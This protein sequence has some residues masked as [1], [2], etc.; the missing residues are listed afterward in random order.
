M[1]Y[2]I[3]GINHKTAPIEIREKLAL[4]AERVRAV[5]ARLLNCPGV[6]ESAV[7]S[8]CNRVEIYG[9]VTDASHARGA[10][11]NFFV[12]ELA[13]SEIDSSLYAL[14]DR[15]AVS[16]LFSVTASLDS[17]VVGEN[18]I[19]RQVKDAYQLAAEASA[20]GPY[21]NRL[22][23]RALF[24][25]KRIRSETAIGKGNVSVGSA[26][27]A[28][29]KKIFGSLSGKNVVLFGA[30]E[31]GELVLRYLS[32]STD[33]AEPAIVNRSADKAQALA[34]EGLGRAHA[35]TE[36]GD[37]LVH[38][39]ILITSVTDASEHLDKKAFEIL[40][41]RRRHRPL[42]IID[43]GLPRNV[44]DSVGR[45]ANVYLYNIDD[46]K[47]VA[48]DSRLART[49]EI[50]TAKNIIAEETRLFYD[51]YLGQSAIPMIAGLNR[52]FEDIRRREMERTLSRLT[53]LSGSDKTALDDMTKAIVARILH[54]PILHLK[55][56]PD[57]DSPVL[58]ALRK[59]FR[60][61]DEGDNE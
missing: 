60:L 22:F 51:S 59:I 15:E 27:V 14:T 43:L 58:G 6:R 33:V 41:Q 9:A 5:L 8:T 29:A 31:V 23:N 32:E 18:Q 56:K 17:L 2:V 24:V 52:K 40:M 55:N 46:L 37:L 50:L 53:H 11:A 45:L 20:T 25:A 61:D 30:G 4:T 35:L 36:L 28:L 16:H 44:D 12:T 10:L 42:F 54:D 38:A 39:D 26:G 49:D 47:A 48:D 1:N 13:T 34:A 19:A 3:V 21:L 7:L 57:A